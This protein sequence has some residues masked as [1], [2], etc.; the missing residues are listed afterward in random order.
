MSQ[1]PTNGLAGVSP[2]RL[3]YVLIRDS[4]TAKKGTGMS[5]SGRICGSCQLCCRLLPT[6]EIDKP[7]LK[8]CQHQKHGVGCAIYAKRPIS[9]E[10]W[11]C[12][13]LINDDANELP[14]PDRAHYVL[15]V[16]GDVIAAVD[17][18]TGERMECPALQVWVDPDYPDAH[19]APTLRRW[20]DRQAMPAIIRYGTTK[21]FVLFPPS[22][23]SDGQWREQESVAGPAEDL[24]EKLRHVQGVHERFGLD[25]EAAA[26]QQRGDR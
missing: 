2:D 22:I 9:C 3:S 23:T 4:A 6:E 26:N 10:L 14:R 20:I 11:N 5:G 19:R 7:A 18:E 24:F 21:G 1:C 16:M 12:R 13:W 17:N 15:D 8:R 25:A